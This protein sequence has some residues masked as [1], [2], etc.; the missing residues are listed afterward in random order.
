MPEVPKIVYQRLGAGAPEASHPD[1]D[2]LTAFAEQTLSAAEREGTLQHLARCGECREWVAL[3]TPPLATAPQPVAAA[4]NEA[5]VTIAAKGRVETG[6]QRSW[7][8]WRG[9]RWAALAA[10][11]AVAG[12]LLLI[13]PGKP[14]PVPEAK[15]QPASI[16]KTDQSVVAKEAAPVPP[17]ALKDTFSEKKLARQRREPAEDKDAQFAYSVAAPTEREMIVTRGQVDELAKKNLAAGTPMGTVVATGP[18]GPAPVPQRPAS[19]NETVQV[20]SSSETVEVT[21]AS[22]PITTESAALPAALPPAKRDDLAVNGRSVADMMTVSKA[23]TA[24]EESE[25][26]AGQRSESQDMKQATSQ[27]STGAAVGGVGSA[28]LAKAKSADV[29]QS[30]QYASQW[31]IRGNDLQRSLGT[32]AE[33]KTVLHSDRPLLS[34]AAG[35]NEIWA[36]GKAG[37]LFHSANGGLTWSQVH[38]LAQ[39]QSLSEDVTQITIYSPSRIV[40]LT[41]NNQMWSTT[42]GGKSWEKK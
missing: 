10:G 41:S 22:G 32:G 15:Q 9:L 38:P 11:V 30:A 26:S 40:L 7:F 33:W 25:A 21:A 18:A 3:S 4:D 31:A 39:S 29:P 5:P 1:P 24:K 6:G 34:Y 42:D 14:N 8:G 19:A 37:D 35:G 23:K 28:V 2:V 20:P 36:G 12:G 13:H 16:V 17:A 27:R